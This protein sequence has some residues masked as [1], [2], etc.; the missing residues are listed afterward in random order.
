MPAQR[1]Y[2][3]LQGAV[4]IYYLD[5]HRLHTCLTP[6]C[7]RSSADITNYRIQAVPTRGTTLTLQGMGTSVAGGLVRTLVCQPLCQAPC[8]YLRCVPPAASLPNQ[9]ML[10]L[11]HCS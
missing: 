5:V 1:S 10:R 6:S 2:S 11:L 7:P 3:G 4:Q 9:T 8:V